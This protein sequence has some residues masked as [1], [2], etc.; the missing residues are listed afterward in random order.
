M[1]EPKQKE[2][3]KPTTVPAIQYSV[4]EVFIIESLDDDDEDNKRYEGRIL[5]DMLR[6][7]GKNPKYYY[8]QSEH[9]LPHLFGLFRQTQFRFLHVSTHATATEISLNH[10]PISYDT[11]ADY[12]SP[13]L[14]TRRLFF[15]ACQI[16]NEN[17]VNAVSAKNKGMHSIVAPAENIDFDHA[18]ALWSAFYISIFALDTN[19]VKHET[20]ETRLRALMKLF[21]V[22]FFLAKYSSVGDKWKTE[23]LRSEA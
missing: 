9:E 11:F 4:P 10:G 23:R 8:F 16:G 17:F 13:H 12:A 21:P 19:A 14:K 2:T 20:I 5:S 1:V 6:L 7:A 18:A 22:D 15:S 3:L